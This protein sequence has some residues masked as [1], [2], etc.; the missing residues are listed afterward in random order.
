MLGGICLLSRCLL[1][2]SVS[3]FCR[4]DL[5]EKDMIPFWVSTHCHYE[6]LVTANYSSND[7]VLFV[8]VLSG[9]GGPDH[10]LLLVRSH[11]VQFKLCRCISSP[12]VTTWLSDEKVAAK[13]TA[14]IAAIK[15]RKYPQ[16]PP[17]EHQKLST[18]K[19]YLFHMQP[20]VGK[21]NITCHGV[22]WFHVLCFFILK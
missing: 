6:S 22:L 20:E 15:K 21:S 8:F 2:L 1:V 10:W 13:I 12:L 16:S 18:I 5:F 19:Q 3:T 14:K 17:H 11:F 7:V 4:L 9:R